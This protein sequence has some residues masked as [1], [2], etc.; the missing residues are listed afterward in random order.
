MGLEARLRRRTIDSRGRDDKRRAEMVATKG[1]V[2][3]LADEV[4]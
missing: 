3:H 2:K 1:R 4:T